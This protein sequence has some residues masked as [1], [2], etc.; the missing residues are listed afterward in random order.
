MTRRSLWE[1]LISWGD[2]LSEPWILMGDFN[3]IL[4]QEERVCGAEVSHYQIKDF[5]DCCDKSVSYT[6]LTL[7]TKRIV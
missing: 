4:R 3:N 6:H 5:S 7:P 1:N 2:T